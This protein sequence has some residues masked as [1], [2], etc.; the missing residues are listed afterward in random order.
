MNSLKIFIKDLRDFLILWLSQSFSSLGSAMTNFALV[1]WSYQQYGSALQTALLAICSYAPYVLMSIFAGALSDRWNKKLT[2]LLCDSFAAGCTV[3]VLILLQSDKLE[4]W[5]LYCLNALNGL[6]NT[7]QQPSADVTT[8]LL[9]PKKYYQ[10]VSGM[11]SFSNSLVS[12]ITPVLAT[13][14]LSLFSVQIVIA[15]DL[16]SFGVAFISLL[17]FI[18]IPELK[19]EDSVKEPILKAAK[20][21]L[22][23]LRQ[24]RG[25]L[26]LILFL[27]AINLIASVYNAA[28]PAMVLSRQ[29]GGEVALGIVNA[30]VGIATLAGSVIVSLLPAPKSRVRVICDTL[31]ISMSTE[32]FFLA[33]GQS[34]PLW[35]IGAVLGWITIPVMGANMDVLFRSRIP[36][37]MQ[38][39]VY[40]ARNTLQFFTIPI[41]YF[42]GGIL[43]DKVFEPFME[44]QGADSFLTVVFGSGKG[45]G[46]ALLFLILAFAGIFVCLFFRKDK[47]IWQLEE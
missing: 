22:V 21:G 23:Y 28:F 15:F 32:N 47:Y 20:A 31:L 3:I 42:L 25:I 13:A 7:V 27:A 35:C 6:M 37:E 12:V 19:R 4:L 33:F 41:G 17:F 9:T 38:G 5:H 24:N 10:K 14:L 1:I 11:R 29:G 34:I 2:M 36:I 46:A 18:K 45:S 43:V 39:R 44:T 26:D 16:F 8:S 30:A 40:S